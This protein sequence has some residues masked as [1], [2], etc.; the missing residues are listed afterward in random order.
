MPVA[1]TYPGVYI[2]EIPSGVRTIVGVPTAVT[3]FVGATRRGP[4]DVPV[5]ITGYGD[6]ER[7]F[8]GLWAGS[9]LGH[10][11]YQYYQN[12]GV[13]AVIVRVSPE[14]SAPATLDLGNNVA[15][16]ASGPGEWGNQLR[17]DVTDALGPGNVVRPDAYTLSVYVEG[18]GGQR[19]EEERY[20]NVSTDPDSAR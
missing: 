16:V 14:G 17:A 9:L 19:Q 1:P 10:E 5:R 18:P 11:V 4:A 13:D 7:L 6:F 15:L 20:V 2:E 12:G 8:G 3:A